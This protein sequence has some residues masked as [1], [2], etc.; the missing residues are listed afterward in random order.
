MCYKDAFLAG[1]D[2][3]LLK[4]K[5]FCAEKGNETVRYWGPVSGQQKGDYVWLG[6]TWVAN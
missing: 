4:F 6:L 2:I 3:G 5:L 1:G